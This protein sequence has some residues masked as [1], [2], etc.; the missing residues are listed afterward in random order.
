MVAPIPTQR[1][2]NQP[3]KIGHM[4]FGLLS[5]KEVRG[6]SATKVITADTYDDDGF[7]IEMGLMDPRLGVIEPGLRC[8]TCGQKV[9]DRSEGRRVGK[10]DCH[11]A[12]STDSEQ[13]SRLE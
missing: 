1:L 9:G 8:K 6:L 3:K 13:Q 7:P 4:E 11:T 10:K 5:P 12:G 2:T